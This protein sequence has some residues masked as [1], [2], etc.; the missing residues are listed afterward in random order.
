M[1]RAPWPALLLTALLL[2]TACAQWDPAGAAATTPATAAAGARSAPAAP[3]A[4]QVIEVA[5]TGGF[6]TPELLAARL[7]LVSVHADGRVITPGPQIQ[8]FPP[9]ALPALQVQHVDEDAVAVLVEHALRAGVDGSAD[10]GRPPV[11]DLPSTRFTVRTAE[12]TY[13]REV[14]ALGAET[15][16]G[17]PAGDRPG[18]TD[19]ALTPEQRAARAGLQALVEELGDPASVL[20][21]D[22]VGAQEVWVPEAVAG[23]VTEWRDPQD[24][25]DPRPVP[26]PGPP[27]PGEPLEPRLGLSCVAATGE[28]ARAVLDAA[29]SADTQTPWLSEDGERWS[30][31]LRPLLPH[32]EGCEDL[33]GW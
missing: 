19:D 3:A 8:V 23:V 16:P 6:T 27:L 9:P 10:L 31:L 13:V 14:Y 24:G 7:P 17:P 26:W 32:E 2:T 4:R 30:V 20:P 12:R 11:A 33:A 29:G 18:S 15:P 22:A 21:E 1:P 25:Q 5:H 28:Q